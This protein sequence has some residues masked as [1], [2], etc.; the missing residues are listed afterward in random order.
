MCFTFA[1]RQGMAGW[2]WGL[3]FSASWARNEEAEDE[4][5]DLDCSDG[6]D[7]FILIST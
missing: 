4:D 6:A 1:R 5:D 2:E 3:L 7:L